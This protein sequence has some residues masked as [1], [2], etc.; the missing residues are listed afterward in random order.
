MKRDPGFQWR[1]PIEFYGKVVDEK[2]QP[3][4]GVKFDIAGTDLSPSGNFYRTL[5]SDAD[6]NVSMKGL[7]GKMFGVRV[8]KEGYYTSQTNRTGFEY[9]SFSDPY[10]YQPDPNNPVIFHLRKKGEPASV[11]SSEGEFVMTFGVPWAVPLPQQIAGDSPIEVTVF[12]N[13]I[14]PKDWK[15]RIS[16]SGGGVQA[17]VEE[18]PF[19]A[20]VDGYQTSIDA[21]YD[22]PHSPGWP[23]DE[24]GFFYVKTPEGYGILTLLQTR[25]K[26]TLHYSLLINS[27]GGR[28]VE[29][30]Q[31]VPVF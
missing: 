10:Y 5:F 27:K 20:P 26:R 13:D 16:V 6:G 18:F 19:Q 30:A 7:R 1:M 3:V 24:G 9:A 28:D 23:D 2:E 12:Q 31:Y 21:A 4:Q 22:S 29:P 17:S 11:V 15:A 14:R 25:G 8:S